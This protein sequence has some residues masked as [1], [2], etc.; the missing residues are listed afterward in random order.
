MPAGNLGPGTYTV[1]YDECQ[2]GTFNA[3]VDAAFVDSFEVILPADI[4][5]IDPAIEALKTTSGSLANKMRLALD[6]L[7]LYEKYEEF[8]QAI[9]VATACATSPSTCALSYAIGQAQEAILD[10]IK[11][12]L[13]LTTDPKQ[14]GRDA[15]LDTINHY[16]AIEA[17][18][19]DPAFRQ[20]SLV[21]PNP[22]IVAS[23]ADPLTIA[24]V[25]VGT[26]HANE[27]ALAEALLHA[28]E[29]YQGADAAGN[30]DWALVHARAIRSYAT[31][32]AAQLA[33]LATHLTNSSAQSSQPTIATWP[34]CPACSSRSSSGSSPTAS[35]PTRI[36]R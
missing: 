33:E 29:R 12:W 5:P 32:L 10:Q 20:P 19:P 21:E 28:V 3:T 27:G 7:E 25:A 2:D 13:G 34:A 31:L 11:L 9:A 14:A 26:A 24:A 8:Q 30:G 23:G 22:R 18:P 4:P 35:R 36:G 16:K 6:E 15:A 17:D 1:V